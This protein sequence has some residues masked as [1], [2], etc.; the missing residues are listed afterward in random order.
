MTRLNCRFTW[1]CVVAAS[2]SLPIDV[3]LAQNAPAANGGLEEIVVSAQRHAES[4]QDVPIAITA[5]SG[6]QLASAGVNTLADMAQVTPGLQ[7]QAIGATSVP[8]LRGIGSAVTPAGSE[9]TVALFV[10]G[11][12]VAA[13]A[14]SLMSLT[15][16][17]SIEVDKGPQGTLFGRNATGG[18]I[19]VR[20]RRPSQESRLDVNVGYGNYE[21]ADGSLYGTTGISS[22][23]AADVSLSYHN[24]RDGYGTNL[25]NG[26]DVYKGYDYVGRSKWLWTPSDV[27]EVTFV[28]DWERLLS[29]TGFATR[30][31]NKGELG[32]DQR[33]LAG[34]QYSGGF[35]DVDLNFPSFNVTE[36]KGGSVDWLQQLGGLNL[37]SISAYHK[38]D[39]HAQVDFDLSPNS[40]SHQT[41]RP[42]QKTFSEELQLLSPDGSK[43]N[44]VAGL[45]YYQ[46][47]SGYH[48]VFIDYPQPNA[49][50]LNDTTIDSEMKTKSWS[51]FGQTTIPL[52]AETRL[53]LGVR[54]TKD[55]R[56]FRLDQT[57][58]AAPP[59]N[60]SQVGSETW[61]KTTF[62]VGLDHRF[63]QDALAYV[64]ASTGFKSGLFNPMTVQ[65][66]PG[67]PASV[68]LAVQPEKITAYE[69]GLKS[70]WLE[71]RLR[72]NI[73]A[74]YYDYKDQ[75]VNAFIGS[76]R[77][78]LNAASSKI[79]GIDF[80]FT[81][82]PTDLLTL[83][84]TGSF[85]HARYDNFPSAP[86]FLPAPA[87]GTGNIVSPFDASGK[88]DVNSPTFTTTVAAN[89]GVPLGAN[90]LDLNA[91]A[92]Y[93]SGYY[94][95][96]ANTRKQDNYTWLNASVKYTF[97]KN[98]AY[99]VSVYSD[100][101]LDEKVYASVN[102]V[103]R[104]PAGLF[105]GD[106][107]T[108][109]APRTYGIRFGA[110][111]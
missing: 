56:D 44:W 72:F 81:G 14:A 52:P 77:T 106:S 94:F 30:L 37:R 74:F 63:T 97:G 87:P 95:D 36:T 46:D 88:D 27:T 54:Y 16:V 7:F 41:F 49:A 85:L 42:S 28:A 47:T 31:P 40:G 103:G 2:I 23:L 29:Q 62:R 100:N 76:T 21:T 86:L 43:L 39:V 99:H 10:D 13:Q 18:V 111:L 66:V 5:L 80:E 3:A 110:T 68:P 24:Q 75:Q 104:G 9:S 6:S 93:N 65:S 38:Q 53:T 11:V 83:S 78:L 32:L 84:W 20:T 91:N 98:A 35:Y 96:F 70:D 48:P 109:R 58:P 26:S 82:K 45:Y 51:A 15:N 92:Y 69:V 107:L 17:D 108:V 73:A 60:V 8:F 22:T 33:G 50:G 55:K 57:A 19:Q 12:Y 105:G 61:P 71:N 25:L 79:K 59:A 102:Q 90:R 4:A 89:Y 101:L 64:Q 67:Q 34:F 1:G